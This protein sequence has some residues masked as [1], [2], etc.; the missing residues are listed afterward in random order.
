MLQN[1]LLT[2]ATLMLTNECI[3]EQEYESTS[4][5]ILMAG[6][7]I[8]FLIEYTTHRVAKTFWDRSRY[9]DELV[10]VMILEAGII[11]HSICK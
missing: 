9:N 1:Q 4:T 2:H 5:A 8:S 10:G 11:F 3:G 7:F 6:L